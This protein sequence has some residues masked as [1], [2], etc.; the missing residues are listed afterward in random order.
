MHAA[1]V[2]NLFVNYYQEKGHQLLSSASLLDP[3]IPMSF[4]MSAGL[5]QV[6]KSLAQI[7]NRDSDKYV[8]VQKCFRHFDVEKVG[9]D[10]IHLSF[11]MMPGAFIFGESD[12]TQIIQQMWEFAT[13]ILE[14]PKERL[15]ASY[16]QG[17]MVLNTRIEEDLPTRSTWLAMGLSPKRVVGLEK[18]HNFWIQGNGLQG[19][20]E[21]RKCGPNTELFYDKGQELACSNNCLPGCNCGRFVEFSNTL[22][23]RYQ[24]D[25][26]CQELIPIAN[27]FTETVVGAERVAMLTDGVSS[28]FKTEEY[29]Y[30]S[31]VIC[32][33]VEQSPTT[34]QDKQKHVKVISDHLKAL[35][36]LVSDGAPPPGKDGR[37]RIIKILIRRIFA[38]QMLLGITSATFL[39][40]TIHAIASHE[41][42]PASSETCS[43][44]ESYFAE[45]TDRFSK[46]ITRGRIQIENML[47]RNNN[48]R[49]SLEQI[50]ILETQGGIPGILTDSIL[51]SLHAK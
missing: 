16:F 41:S 6:E 8:L 1:T 20:A 36:H 11:F 5:V 48:N 12:C 10:E 24:T 42:I 21:P 23:I 22:F 15:W 3:S 9:N 2:C 25:H 19:N 49:L 30:I 26:I 31:D 34:T 40:E 33:F 32:S 39:R 35:Y 43:K 14:F 4:V 45:E 18:K 29:S 38:R 13:N 51:E 27:P 50:S 47:S 28:V 7:K 44:L 37:Q 17:D 46:T